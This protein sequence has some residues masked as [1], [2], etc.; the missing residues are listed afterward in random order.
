M[1]QNITVFDI[2]RYGYCCPTG[3][4]SHVTV[5]LIKMCKRLQFQT[6]LYVFSFNIKV[7]FHLFTYQRLSTPPERRI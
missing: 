7:K 6:N 1:L 5:F 4:S 3:H 2:V